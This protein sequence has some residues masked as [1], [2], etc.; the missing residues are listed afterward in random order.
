MNKF[1]QGMAI[2]VCFVLGA[3]LGHVQASQWDKQDAERN[4]KYG[5]TSSQDLPE[6][7]ACENHTPGKTLHSGG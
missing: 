1:D 3:F 2:I 6:G 5:I 4:L 7:Q